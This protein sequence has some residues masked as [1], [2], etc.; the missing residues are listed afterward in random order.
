MNPL[1]L[2]LYVL[3][4]VLASVFAFGADA[5]NEALLAAS[6]GSVRPAVME[7]LRIA[8]CKMPLCVNAA[9]MLSKVY[10]CGDCR[11]NHRQLFREVRDITSIAPQTDEYGMWMESGDGFSLSYYG[12]TPEMSAVAIYDDEG[13]KLHNFCYFFLFPYQEARRDRAVKEQT[14]FTGALLQEMYDM[15]MDLYTVSD[16][17]VMM[18]AV[19]HYADNLVELRLMEEDLRDVDTTEADGRF[20]LVVRVEPGKADVLAQH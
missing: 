15:G 17:E 20:L 10:G 14:E 9:D 18:D 8:K 19:T 13:E 2:R 16:P 4:P 6:A 1:A 5:G 7:T 3:L 11:L 12:M